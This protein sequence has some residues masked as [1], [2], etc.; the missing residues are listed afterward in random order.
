M[1]QTSSESQVKRLEEQLSDANRRGDDLQRALTELSVAKN[2]LTGRVEPGRNICWSQSRLLSSLESATQLS[3]LV[4]W[5]FF[6]LKVQ[7]VKF[8]FILES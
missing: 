8:C 5:I 1:L 2:R 3:V 7:C 6:S 4:M